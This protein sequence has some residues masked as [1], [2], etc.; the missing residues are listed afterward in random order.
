MKSLPTHITDPVFSEPAV[1]SS[2]DQFFLKYIRDERDLPFI[3][4]TLKIIFLF[5][6]FAVFL[7]TNLFTGWQ[8]VAA[9]LAYAGLNVAFFIGRFALMFHCIAHRILFKKEFNYLNAFIPY[10]I[11]P[12]FGH[13]AYTFYAHHV[14]MHHAENNLEDDESTTMPYQRDSV[15]SFLLYFSRFLLVGMYN[16]AA[17][18][19]KRNRNKL[20]QSLLRGEL[21]FILFTVL[22]CFVNWPAT[23]CVFVFP[24]FF[25]RFVAMFGNWA[26]HAFIDPLDPGNSYKNSITC[27]NTK[28]NRL[29]WNDGY[30]ISHHLKQN[31][32][33]TEHPGYFKATI[34]NYSM[35][36][37]V[38]FYKID[39][40]L[41]S[42]F[43]LRKRYDLLAKYFVNVGDRFKSDEEIILF[44][45]ERV[46][47][48][49]FVKDTNALVVTE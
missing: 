39:F 45:K 16:A 17:Y 36:D 9:A 15:G 30:H 1:Y 12:F 32:H 47:R 37:A 20:I 33:W 41:V 49:T 29:C 21:L 10:F 18:F 35:N 6:P 38:V 25:Y 22:M 11:A 24:Y 26:Q 46:Q 44:L 34:A 23:L 28:Y 43:L 40:M 48:F 13:M 31:L 5:I 27:I 4:F 42:L 14:G 3:Y 7:Y 8:W 2:L 19:K